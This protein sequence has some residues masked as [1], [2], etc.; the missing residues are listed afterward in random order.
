MLCK[1]QVELIRE[2]KPSANK[3]KG[4]TVFICSLGR[5]HAV[6]KE[7]SSAPVIGRTMWISLDRMHS[8]YA[9]LSFTRMPPL[10]R[11]RQVRTSFH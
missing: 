2:Q 11:P 9:A 1:E 3:S 4:T 7:L 8:K 10:T 6:S 5:L